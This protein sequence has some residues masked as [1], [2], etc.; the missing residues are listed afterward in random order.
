MAVAVSIAVMIRRRFSVERQ[1]LFDIHATRS[2]AGEDFILKPLEALFCQYK[3]HARLVTVL[4]IAELGEDFNDR[5]GPYRHVFDANEL[6][7]RHC[8]TRP[9]SQ[10][11]GGHQTEP[12]LLFPVDDSFAA[13]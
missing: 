10:T 5:L 12:E 9:A 4:A 8:R 13:D 1:G 3:F 7:N 11:A 6:S 2:D